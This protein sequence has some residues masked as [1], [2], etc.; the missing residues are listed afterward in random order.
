MQETLTPEI[1]AFLICQIT[2]LLTC[3]L[4]VLTSL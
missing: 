1:L 3:M 2:F 4:E